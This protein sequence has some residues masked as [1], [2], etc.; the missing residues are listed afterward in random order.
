MLESARA[1]LKT[2]FSDQELGFMWDIAKGT[3]WTPESIPLIRF[4]IMDGLLDSILL[5]K[6]DVDANTCNRRLTLF[7][8]CRCMPWLLHSLV[9]LTTSTLLGIINTKSWSIVF[10][11]PRKEK[12]MSE[13]MNNATNNNASGD[14]QE[15]TQVSVQLTDEQK[16][17]IATAFGQEYA[18]RVQAVDV[19]HA[20]GRLMGT[21]RVN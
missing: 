19:Q 7:R 15:G 14:H 5:V 21:L 9:Q 3:R 8:L 16:K 18:D 4:S 2:R 17:Q 11:A 1:G 10:L 6:W 20:S 13:D 12:A